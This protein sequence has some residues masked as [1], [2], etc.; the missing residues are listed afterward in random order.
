MPSNAITTH[1]L[2]K[3]VNNLMCDSDWAIIISDTLKR[4]KKGFWSNT[5]ML[6]QKWDRFGDADIY[7]A[8]AFT[9]F[10]SDLLSGEIIQ[11]CLNVGRSPC[12]DKG[13]KANNQVLSG[14]PYPFIGKFW[15]GN[16]GV[17]GVIK[18]NYPIYGETMNI[19]DDVMRREYYE[20]RPSQI[21]IEVG[22]TSAA[23]T[24]HQLRTCG[25][26]RWPYNS[27]EIMIY[28]NFD[29]W[30]DKAREITKAEYFHAMRNGKFDDRRLIATYQPSLFE[31]SNVTT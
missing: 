14:L 30:G 9:Q 29:F 15:G 6:F 17:D 20:I 21:S 7:D 16:Q 23:K 4:M 18:W 3:Y 31:T 27:N 26:A 25:I 11:L 19:S 1:Y 13:I 12:A 8:Y 10:H 28:L 2:T 22:Y 24:L 5:D